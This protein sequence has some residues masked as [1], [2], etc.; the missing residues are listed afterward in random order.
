M[1]AMKAGSKFGSWTL[2][3]GKEPLVVQAKI[4]EV[5]TN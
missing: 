4:S 2:L 1:V 3:G 5:T